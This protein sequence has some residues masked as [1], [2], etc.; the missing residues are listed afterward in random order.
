MARPISSRSSRAGRGCALD[1]VPGRGESHR[2]EISPGRV[3]S[4]EPTERIHG[5]VNVGKQPHEQ[6]T[7]FW[8]N[9]PDAV[10]PPTE[11]QVSS[12]NNPRGAI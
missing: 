8:L 5:A 12:L 4:E 3:D 9:R 6:V 1:R 11:E 7:V 2:V 10:P